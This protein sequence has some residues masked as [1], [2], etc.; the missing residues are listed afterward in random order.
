MNI[1]KNGKDSSKCPV[2]HIKLCSLTAD[3]YDTNGLVAKSDFM[4]VKINNILTCLV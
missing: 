4:D 3:T 2:I 1:M